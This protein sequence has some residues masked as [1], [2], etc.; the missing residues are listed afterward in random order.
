MRTRCSGS[1]FKKKCIAVELMNVGVNYLHEH[2]IPKACITTLQI[3]E[4]HPQML[5][6]LLPEFIMGG[7]TDVR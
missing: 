7:S 1:T 2:I 3:Q 6:S 5:Y 4:E